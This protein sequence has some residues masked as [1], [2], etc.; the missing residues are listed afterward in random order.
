MLHSLIDEVTA[1]LEDYEP[2]RAGRAIEDFVETHLSNW[3][4]R[5]SRKR[6]WVGDM[7][8]DKECAY[9][10]LYECLVTVAKLMAPIAPFYADR[11]Y[12]DLTLSDE[13]VHLADFPVPNKEVIDAVLERRMARAQALT[14]MVLALRRKV[15]IKVRQPLSSIMVLIDSEEK[16]NDIEAVSKWILNE[17]NVKEI[18]YEDASAD[19]WHRTIKPDFKKLG[20]RYGKI[21][22]ALAQQIASLS[23]DEITRLDKE[24]QLN[25]QIG[26]DEVQ[27]LRDDV[28][29]NVED[30]PGRL[31]ATD[32]HDTVALDVTV[33]DELYVEGLARELVNRI[34]NLRKQMNFEVND[35][36]D[37]FL[38]E[39]TE[40]DRAVNTYHDYISEQVQ[41]DELALSD[42]VS[43][44]T[45]IDME[46]YTLTLS[47]SK[48]ER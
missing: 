17:V 11:L 14:G 10:T 9:A 18:R 37:V 35:H 48:S 5:L 19:I 21:M 45:D 27:L 30:I 34:Q 28:T 25:L 4:V 15:N 8:V 20:P 31:V 36:I 24:G 43:D 6:F 16:K 12:R 29:I 47:I 46:S 2:T 7:T 1:S 32:G 22:K 42:A 44:G 41:A 3:Y 13:S 23:Q 39:G 33:S 38:L 40:M 26:N